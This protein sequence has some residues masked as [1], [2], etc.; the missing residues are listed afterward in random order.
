MN[1]FIYKVAKRKAKDNV[2]SFQDEQG[3]I[4]WLLF[5][6]VSAGAS[7]TS[8]HGYGSA[9]TEPMWSYSHYLSKISKT[10]F[11]LCSL[12]KI[13]IGVLTH[14]F[15]PVFGWLTRDYCMHG[16][17]NLEVE[18][19]RVWRRKRCSRSWLVPSGL[20]FWWWCIPSKSNKGQGTWRRNDSPD[21]Y[22]HVMTRRSKQQDLSRDQTRV[23]VSPKGR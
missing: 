10:M 9:G 6:F 18:A 12:N 21:A 13:T 16:T 5:C 8:T 15:K 20:S 7:N 17:I 19:R 14:Q 23:L 11:S 3:S 4:E 22:A 1:L 2:P